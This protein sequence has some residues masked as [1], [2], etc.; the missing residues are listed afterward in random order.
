MAPLSKI[1]FIDMASDLN[2]STR[3]LNYPTDLGKEIYAKVYATGA[4]IMS[5]SWGGE[6]QGY[7][8][9]HTQVKLHSHACACACACVC[10]CD[11]YIAAALGHWLRLKG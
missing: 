10:V 8:T 2:N 9:S 7:P 11:Y 5:E 6:P 1:A 3:D 4:R